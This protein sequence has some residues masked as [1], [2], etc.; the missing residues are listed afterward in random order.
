M[1]RH[2]WAALG[3]EI[4]SLICFENSQFHIQ[5]KEHLEEKKTGAI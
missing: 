1:C 2:A 5:Y 4:N 3:H